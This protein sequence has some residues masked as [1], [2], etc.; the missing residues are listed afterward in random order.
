MEKLGLGPNILMAKNPR[1]IY[2][3]LNGYGSYGQY[4]QKA[5]HDINYVAISGGLWCVITQHICYIHILF[6]SYNKKVYCLYT[7]QRIQNHFL[8]PIFPNL[9]VV[10]WYV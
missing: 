1:L 5:G 2:A 4:S 6:M 10:V 8:Q 7:A 9:R 3:R